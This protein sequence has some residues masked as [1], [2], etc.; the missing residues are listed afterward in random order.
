[1]SVHAAVCRRP[2]A[3]EAGYTL[4]ELLVST[5]VMLVVTGSIFTL[6]NPGQHTFRAQPEVSDMQQRMRVA[7]DMLSKDLTM[8]GAGPYQG[9]ASGSLSK[10]FSPVLPYRM[11][12]LNP[13]PPQT[14]RDDTITMVYVPN[15][16]AQTTIRDPMPNVSAE[17]KVNAQPGCPSGDDL[18][19]FKEGMSL[20]IFDADGAWESFEVTNVQTSALHLQHR[21]QQF[22]KSY[23]AGANIVQADYHTYYYCGPAPARP[24]PDGGSNQLRHYDG[25]QTDLPLVDNVVGLRFR[26]FGDVNPPEAPRPATGVA[27]CVFDAGGNSTM[28]VLAPTDGEFAELTQAMLTDGPWC[29]SAASPNRY[30]ADLLRLRKVR[31][32]LRV[33]AAADDLRGS[34]T[35]LF[36]NPGTARIGQR[37]VSDYGTAFEIAPRNL[38]LAR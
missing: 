3:S 24:C 26:Y 11:G 25:L 38:N 35:A 17:I 37:F 19:G 6:V 16:A 1:M 14:F 7:S 34:S 8:A 15:T 13:D 10:F 23:D 31:I 28:P 18:C 36:R 12:Q 5:T 22:T 27:N 9:A 4:V 2:T 32:T 30:D 20:L 29:P 33:Q 21:G